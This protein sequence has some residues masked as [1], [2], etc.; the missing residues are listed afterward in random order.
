[1]KVPESSRVGPSGLLVCSPKCWSLTRGLFVCV[2]ALPQVHLALTSNNTEMRVMWVTTDDYTPQTS[3]TVQWGTTS[4]SYPFT[5]LPGTSYTYTVPKRW[6]GGFNGWIHEAVITGLVRDH[7]VPPAHPPA[8]MQC[9]SLCAATLV[10]S[11]L[12]NKWPRRSPARSTFTAWGASQRPRQAAS[13]GA[14]SSTSPVPSPTRRT[15]RRFS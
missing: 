2:C 10:V 5:S 3:S 12:T 15:R 4:G 13:H 7:H 6:W 11:F 8:H 1:M 9:S 14:Q